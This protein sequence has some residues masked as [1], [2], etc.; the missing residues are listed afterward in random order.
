VPFELSARARRIALAGITALMM[1]GSASA[2]TLVYTPTNPS[3]GGNPL[4]GPT[5]LSAASAQNQHLGTNDPSG[6]GNKPLTQGQ[7]F[8]QQLTSQLYASLANSI[9]KAIF[10]DSAQP[11]GTFTFAGTTITYV[12]VGDQV[13]L[14]INDGST[15]TTITLPKT[16]I[17]N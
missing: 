4:N 8:A 6:G 17:G 7:I 12:T 1:T 11:N 3:F 2:G 16:A 15:S 9:T 14:T 10:G 13:Q 5:L